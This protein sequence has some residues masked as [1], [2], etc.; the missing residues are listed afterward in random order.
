VAQSLSEVQVPEHVPKS[1]QTTPEPRCDTN[2]NPHVP[3]VSAQIEP[4]HPVLQGVEHELH[5]P[6]GVVVVV[7]DDVV[8]VVVATARIATSQSS[9]SNMA[10]AVSMHG[11]PFPAWSRPTAVWPSSVA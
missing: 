8:G 11:D 3:E 9:M 6:G 1:G 4:L 5:V 10:D 7:V 2:P